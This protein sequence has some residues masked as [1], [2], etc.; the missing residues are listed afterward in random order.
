MSPFLDTP[1]TN[2]H[3]TTNPY[4]VP[5]TLLGYRRPIK[6]I[7]IGFGIS[8]INLSY[9][10]GK[11]KNSNIT[12]QFYEKNP[13]LGGTWFENTYP[14]CSCDIP[15]VNYQFTWHPSPNWSSYYA[16]CH[17]TLAYLKSVVA[18]HKL[19]TN[20]KYNHRLTGAWWDQETARWRVRIQPNDDPA[21]EFYD[22]SDILIT[23][24]GVLNNWKWPAIRGIE[25][26]KNKMHTAAWD[27]SV[28]LNNKTVGVIGNGSSSVQLVPAI[29]DKVKR[30]STFLRSPTWITAGYAPKYAGEG[31]S[32]I[33]YTDEQKKHFA[34]NPEEYLAYRKAVEREMNSNF[35]VMIKDTPAQLECFEYAVNEM[36]RKLSKKPELADKLI[37]KTFAVGCRRA[38]PGHG[39]LEAI[40][41]EK[42]DVIFG[43]IAEI[44]EE[45]VVA[46]DGV[47]HKVDVLAC[48]TGFDVSFKPKFPIV[49]KDGLS[50]REAFKD[51]PDTYLSI[52]TPGFPNYFMM[53]GP[54]APYG[55]GSVIPA[56]EVITRYISMALEKF[57]TQNIRSLVPKKEAVADFREH[58]DLYMKKTV[59]DAPCSSW[60]KLGPKGETVMMWPGS[61]LHCFNALW[62]PRWE[63]YDWEYLMSNRF[64]YW[65][66]GFTTTDA[67]EEGTDKAWY[68]EGI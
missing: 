52:M 10:L 49:G 26:F 16:P 7:V 40:S 19:D 2:G 41:S 57:Q 24:T 23:A 53:L 50:L 62:N 5:D 34:E 17:E 43:E 13:E 44:T 39:Y 22:Y 68:I 55:H 60:F 51:L 8:G 9:I 12:L 58:R 61:R 25:K 14:G 47:L 48:G 35:G 31:G 15:A 36:K 45:G 29:Y 11:Q 66:N 32:N 27:H 38:N 20:V 30:I 42:C 67:E 21:A 56:I 6:V 18:H 63:D 65:G 64:S 33:K 4:V 59:W 46:E 54:F 37:P 28:D 1:T 3:I